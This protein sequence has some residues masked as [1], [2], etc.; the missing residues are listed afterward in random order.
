MLKD[1]GIAPTV[2]SVMVISFFGTISL[3]AF[4]PGLIFDAN[5]QVILFLFGQWSALAG[6]AVAYWLGSSNSSARKDEVNAKKDEVIQTM[7]AT[8]TG[9]GAG[10]SVIP[11]TGN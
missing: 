11:P 4:K 9:T 3:L 1:R 10:G 5:Q 6:V 2:V 7:A 8:A